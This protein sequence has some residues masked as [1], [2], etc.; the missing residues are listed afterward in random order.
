VAVLAMVFSVRQGE[1]GP[2]LLYKLDESDTAWIVFAPTE[3]V[4]NAPVT[5]DFSPDDSGTANTSTG[6][7][8]SLQA[9]SDDITWR[10]DTAEKLRQLPVGPRF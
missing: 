4:K 9:I 2:L 5:L 7:W 6:E 3:T 1:N 10:R 8:L